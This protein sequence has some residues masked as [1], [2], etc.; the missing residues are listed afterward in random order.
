MAIVL[1]LPRLYDA[2]VARFALDAAAL[3]PP[4]PPAPNVF[5]W[6]K[7]TEQLRTSHRVAWVPGDD[8]SGELGA[9]GPAKAPGRNPRPLATLD[10]IFTVYLDAFDIA[11][12]NDERAQYE[13]ARQLFDAWWRAVYLAARG[14]VSLE[15]ATWMVERKTARR[16]ATIRA[17]CRIEAM[18]PDAASEVAPVDVEASVTAHIDPNDTEGET[19]VV[20]PS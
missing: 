2:V 17:L 10:E 18:V 3:D 8:E 15:R 4:A 13:A 11:A 1:A 6:R 19:E 20:E 14:T 7:P 9:L 12:P 16:G 5:G